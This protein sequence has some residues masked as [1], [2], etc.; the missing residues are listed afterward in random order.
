MQLN[1]QPHKSSSLPTLHVRKKP[2]SIVLKKIP[3]KAIK[4]SGWRK[5]FLIQNKLTVT[6]DRWNSHPFSILLYKYH[7][8]DWPITLES[9]YHSTSI[10]P[11]LFLTQN[12]FSSER[13]PGP[14]TYPTEN[15]TEGPFCLTSTT[16]DSSVLESYWWGSVRGLRELGAQREGCCCCCCCCFRWL[17]ITGEWWMKVMNS[18]TINEGAR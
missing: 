13:G 4:K 15:G 1:S 16:W 12:S 14:C 11:V 2:E 3:H 10:G 7:Y 17:A 6:V 8:F 5:I 9:A 18:K